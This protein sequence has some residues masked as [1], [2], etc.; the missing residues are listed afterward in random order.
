M[1]GLQKSVERHEQRLAELR[2]MIRHAEEEVAFHQAMVDLAR[3]GRLIALISKCSDNPTLP[4]RLACDPLGIC[5]EESVT[6]PTALRSM[7][8]PKG[9]RPL[10]WSVSS[11]VESVA[12]PLSD[13][14]SETNAI[15]SRER[16]AVLAGI[17][18]QRAALEGFLR[19]E[20]QGLLAALTSEREAAMRQADG[21]ARGLVDQV[22]ERLQ[23][24]CS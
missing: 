23:R 1:S 2:Q 3:N 6:Y 13:L 16:A 8:E 11:T 18:G 9:Y 21:V 15:V 17:D 5:R 20:R 10:I 14:A 19:E 7:R 12:E 22:F 4:S 24:L